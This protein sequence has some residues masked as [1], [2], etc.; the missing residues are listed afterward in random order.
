MACFAT[1]KRGYEGLVKRQILNGIDHIDKLDFLSA[2]PAA[3]EKALIPTSIQSGFDATGLVPYNPDRV[4]SKLTIRVKTPTPPPSRG[5]G[6]SSDFIPETPQNIRQLQ[7][8]VSSLQEFLETGSESHSTST[9]TALHQL[10]EGYQLVVQGTA[11]L[12]K[13]YLALRAANAK[14]R[15]KRT[16][17]TRQIAHDG[18]LNAQEFRALIEAT[19]SAIPTEAVATAGVQ[20]QANTPP[21]RAQPRCSGCRETGHNIRNCTK[22]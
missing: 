5:S 4:L 10:I 2:Y 8:Q 18:S 9:Q 6:Y 16:R 12:A 7:R 17:S 1:L 15:Q 21:R 22:Q 20:N 13:E 19:E 11:L 3:R 14:Q